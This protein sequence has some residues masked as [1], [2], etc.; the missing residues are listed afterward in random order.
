M[1]RAAQCAVYRQ[2]TMSKNNNS[3]ICINVMRHVRCGDFVLT[4][5]M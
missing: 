1:K 5:L 4:V 3:N 2:C